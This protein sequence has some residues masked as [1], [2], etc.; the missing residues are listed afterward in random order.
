MTWRRA[1]SDRPVSLHARCVL[2]ANGANARRGVS[3]ISA[4][5]AR[6]PNSLPPDQ[7]ASMSGPQPETFAANLPVKPDAANRFNLSVLDK[8]IGDIPGASGA[9]HIGWAELIDLNE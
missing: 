2:T 1:E 4:L 8:D 9:A 6:W 5:A 7:R 3:A